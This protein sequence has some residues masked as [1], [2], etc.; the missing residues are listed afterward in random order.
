M[1]AEVK[2]GY[3]L[4]EVGVIPEDWEVRRIG[5]LKPFITSGS[6]GWA[7]FYS[8]RGA[9]FIRIT[10]LVRTSIFLDLKDL[11][12]VNLPKDASEGT[13]TQLHDDDVLISITAD[14]GII[15]YVSP[16]VPKP[17]YINQHIALV[18]FDASTISPKFVAYF[19]ASD[20]PQKLFRALTDSGAKAGMSLITVQNILLAFPPTKAEQAAISEALSDADALIESLEQLITKKRQ[21]KQGA[22]QELLNPLDGWKKVKLGSLGVF[23][24]GS[25]VKKDESMSGN[26]PCIR[27][28]EIYTKHKYYIKAFDSWISPE[29]AATA[30]RIKSGDILFAGS[31]ETKE[32]IGKCVAF[33]GNIEAYAGGDIVI[34]RPNN[35]NSLFLG[36]YL[37]T[38]SV[39]R[40][41]ASRGQGDAVVHIGSN[42]LADIDLIIPHVDEQAVIASVLFDMDAEI[43]V[44]EAKLE[45]ALQLKRGMMHN[46]LTGKIR[47]V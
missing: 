38:E 3:K 26:I 43:G 25:G 32:E 37:N 7:E 10:N 16:D 20:K 41:K 1:N 45:K 15:S 35:A 30:K 31:G 23:L 9:P 14:I 11:R 29:V 40:Q 39:N 6:R 21:I 27:Y 18:R 34:F 17:A 24:K 46:L 36:C 42:A 2:P 12:L 44:L 19:L 33:V 47:L 13:R 22:M 8:D 4:T 5:E 28:G